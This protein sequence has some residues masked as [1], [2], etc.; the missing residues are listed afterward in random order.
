MQ[1]NIKSRQNRNL[2]NRYSKLIYLTITL[3]IVVILHSPFYILGSNAEVLVHDQLDGELLTY[4]MQALNWNNETLIQFMG[5][6]PKTALTPPALGFIPL[7][8]VVDP[9]VAY[10]VMH[11]FILLISAVGMFLC[12]SEITQKHWIG[13]IVA[14]TFSLLPFYTVYGLSVMGQPLLL[15]ALMKIYKNENL[16]RHYFLCFFYALFSS[17]VL[18]GVFICAV[19]FLFMLY[20]FAIK[21][22]KRM[23]RFLIALGILGVTYVILNWPLFSQA[24][25]DQGSILSH[26]AKWVASPKE[27]MKEFDMLYKEGQYHAASSHTMILYWLAPFSIFSSL[28][29]IKYGMFSKKLKKERTILFIF[30]VILG[31]ILFHL[32][33]NSQIITDIKNSLGGI[34]ITFQDRFYWLNTCLWY[35]IYALMLD[36]ISDYNFI[37]RY[38]IP[39]VMSITVIYS[40]S[41]TNIKWLNNW[42][43]YLNEDRAEEEITLSNVT[44]AGFYDED[45]FRMI[46]NYIES[47]YDLK[48][49]EYRI[50]SVGLYPSVPLYN[51]FYTAD[52]YSNNY[53]LSY[54]KDF[55]RIIKDE[56]EKNEEISEYFLEWGNR[57]YIFSAELRKNYFLSKDSGAVIYNL[58]LDSEALKNLDVK[59]ILS[60]VP[61]LNMENS[62]FQLIEDFVT[63]TSTYHIYLYEVL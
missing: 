29:A 15:Y 7:F 24:L 42:E 36:V 23:T 26:R 54:K 60:G 46:N 37:L 62:N 9:I 35:L 50:V 38:V 25:F 33:W 2:Y 56:L 3:L 59:F 41:N 28:K 17:F 57:S 49:E 20:L 21:D 27:L 19:L 63:P 55:Y 13:L 61:I 18:V 31:I 32:F 45:N 8:K 44:L 12:I 39:I 5:G 34:F 51:G 47:F 10:Q 30:S 48:K 22:F 40:V 1:S 16:A 53:E 43:R 4:Y 52:G 11:W 14:L 6:Q 58:N